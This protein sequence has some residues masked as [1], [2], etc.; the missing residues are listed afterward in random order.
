VHLDGIRSH[1][2]TQWHRQSFRGATGEPMNE[3]KSAK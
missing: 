2:I 1:G 3:V